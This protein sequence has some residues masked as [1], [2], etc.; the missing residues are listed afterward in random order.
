MS[1]ARRLRVL[2]L[3]TGPDEYAVAMVRA[4]ST[5]AE[6]TFA[7]PTVMMARFADE[8]AAVARLDEARWPRHRDP[9]NLLLVARILRLVRQTRPDVL[10]FLG[11]SVFWLALLLPFLR[12]LPKIVTVHD[13]T[14]HPGDVASRTVPT[15]T[16]RMLRH[17]ADALIVHGPGLRQDLIAS[18][19]GHAADVHVVAHPVLDRHARL[20]RRLALQR[21]G[22]AGPCVLFFG[23]VMAYK[24][25]DLLIAASD[26]IAIRFPDIRFI[27]AGTGPDLQRLRPALAAR[28]WFEVRDRYV[29]DEETA[30]LFCDADILALPYIEA[31]QSGVLALAAGFGLPV[32]ATDLGEMGSLVRASGMGSTVPPEAS[33]IAEAII[34]L[35]AEPLRHGACAAAARQAAQGILSPQGVAAATL[36]VYRQ[37]LCRSRTRLPLPAASA[38]ARE[39][40]E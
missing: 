8:L 35:L 9:R 28:P 27:V 30:Q 37:T 11:D 24:G 21:S 18:G 16:I 4:L 7:V 39:T 15:T 23:R 29:G 31:S 12:G 14:F 20:A 19:V 34:D 22:A 33:A 2:C 36:S 1:A 13:V 25:L 32:V 26:R 40:S 3:P 6:V 10:H 17:A 38:T 5:A